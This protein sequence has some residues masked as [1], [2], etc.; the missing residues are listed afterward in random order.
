MKEF[1]PSGN[2]RALQERAAQQQRA[3]Q[4]ERR[5]GRQRRRRLQLR[6]RSI[7]AA[8]LAFAAAG[9]GYAVETSSNGP[10]ATTHPAAAKPR[11]P[12]TARPRRRA[13]TLNQQLQQLQTGVKVAAGH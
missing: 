9:I 4:Q 7:A 11:P 2:L 3:A 10:A 1:A 6:N 8:A 5:S 12:V 13:P